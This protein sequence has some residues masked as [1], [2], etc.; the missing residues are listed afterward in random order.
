VKATKAD[1]APEFSAQTLPAGTAPS[2]STF[3]PNTTSE[4]PGQTDNDD[5]DPEGTTSA[6]DSLG[7]ATSGD[8]NTGLGYPGSGQTSAELHHNGTSHRKR[9]GNG[10][11][12]LDGGKQAGGLNGATGDYD[13]SQRALDREEATDVR[14]ARGDKGG[15]YGAGEVEPV[16]A[17][18][19][20]GE[21]KEGT[22]G[23]HR[24]NKGAD[25]TTSG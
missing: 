3:T 12:G 2:E 25:P 16:G 18:A 20:A 14:G 4:I 10:L 19:L 1:F 5:V 23:G 17:E 11:A 8:V 15:N 6:L 7:G 21:L 22:R 24:S 9:E 13:A